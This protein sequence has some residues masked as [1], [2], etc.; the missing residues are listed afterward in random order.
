MWEVKKMSNCVY[1]AIEWTQT[2]QLLCLWYFTKT[3]PKLINKFMFNVHVKACFIVN[4]LRVLICMTLVGGWWL[5]GMRRQP[6]TAKTFVCLCW[7]CA[8]AAAACS[9][10]H[11]HI[12][13]FLS[14]FFAT[15]AA[16]WQLSGKLLYLN[17]LNPC[18]TFCDSVF[19]H[20]R[21]LL[22]SWH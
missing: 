7:L 10:A 16:L 2:L 22:L 18:F 6:P 11:F 21:S 17:L 8:P 15:I 3:W 1:V 12:F 9:F 13:Y 5:G 4:F 19:I 20:A 14:V